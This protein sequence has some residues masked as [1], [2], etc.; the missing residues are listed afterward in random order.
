MRRLIYS[1]A[2]VAAMALAG[3]SS[4]LAQGQII[5][6]NNNAPGV[7]F[8]DP[9][10]AAPVGGNPGMTLGQ[11]RLNVFEHAANIWEQVLQPKN[12]ILVQRA[13]R[14]AGGRTCSALPAPR[15]CSQLPRRRVSGHL[16]SLG[17]R[18]PVWPARS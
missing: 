9:T 1:V 11:Q 18:R 17:A 7:G 15:S 12:D 8:N 14:P 3:V 5:I 13:V 4:A 2:A 6:I 10:P 16:V